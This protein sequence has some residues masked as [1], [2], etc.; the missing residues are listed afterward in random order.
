[1][2]IIGKDIDFC[3]SNS[4]IRK[5]VTWFAAKIIHSKPKIL[6]RSSA[7][8][9]CPLNLSRYLDKVSF[10]G[11]GCYCLC[12]ACVLSK[13]DLLWPTQETERSIISYA[14]L[15]VRAIGHF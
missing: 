8:K 15:F 11:G 13:I 4:F 10:L 12:H 6:W 2:S 5:T 3:V 1:M 14:S 9:N 7:K